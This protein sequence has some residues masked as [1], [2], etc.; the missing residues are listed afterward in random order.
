MKFL[1]NK[2]EFFFILTFAVYRENSLIGEKTCK[3]A[4]TEIWTTMP[5]PDLIKKTKKYLYIFF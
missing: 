5:V 2:N 1:T 4:K 3:Y